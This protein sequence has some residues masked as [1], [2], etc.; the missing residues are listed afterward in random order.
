MIPFVPQT[1]TNERAG[2]ERSNNLKHVVVMTRRYTTNRH[3]SEIETDIHSPPVPARIAV[4][5]TNNIV[6][7]G[8]FPMIRTF[9]L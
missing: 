2:V 3:M 6:A 7:A 8:N 1:G 9:L 5:K 4:V